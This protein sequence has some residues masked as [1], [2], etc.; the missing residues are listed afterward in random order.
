MNE[1]ER[2]Y[3]DLNGHLV[4]RNVLSK[5]TL[6]AAN[7]AIDHVADK[8]AHGKDAESDFLRESGQPMYGHDA[9]PHE[10]QHSFPAQAESPPL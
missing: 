10:Q 3:W 6:K 9:D 2:Y 5:K 7:D 8:C 4:V 1:K